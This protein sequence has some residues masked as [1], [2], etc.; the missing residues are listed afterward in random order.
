MH[1]HESHFESCQTHLWRSNDKLIV[2]ADSCR[3]GVL[4][5]IDVVVQLVLTF[6]RSNVQVIVIIAV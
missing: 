1:G 5:Q 3:G 2:A 4:W 6:D